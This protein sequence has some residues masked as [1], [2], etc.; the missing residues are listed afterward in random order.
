MIII[1]SHIHLRYPQCT[2]N[3][4]PASIIGLLEGSTLVRA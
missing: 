1:A 3:V 2:H 4:C